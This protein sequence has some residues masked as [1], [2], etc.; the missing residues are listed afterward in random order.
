ML[1]SL[2]FSSDSRMLLAGSQNPQER[3]GDLILWNTEICQIIRRFETTG[4]VTSIEFSADNSRAITGQGYSPQVTLW[5]VSTGR[6]IRRFVTG[7]NPGLELPILNVA[8]GPGDNTIVGSSVEN[9]YQWD[10]ESGEILHVYR[11]HTGIP[12]SLSVSPDGGY[13]V[14]GSEDGEIILWEFSTGEEL[15]RLETHVQGINSVTFSPDG[16]SVYSFSSSGLL[17]QWQIP[18]LSQDALL[19]WIPANRYVPQLTCEERSHYRVKPLCKQS[20]MTER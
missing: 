2:A 18:G 10:I 14:S 16:K 6:E 5:D 3:S 1:R 20:A 9:L 11:G 12:W 15:Y 13:L 4:D 7:Q 17:T 19:D 8:F